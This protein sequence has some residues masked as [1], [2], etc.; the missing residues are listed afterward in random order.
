MDGCNLWLKKRDRRLAGEIERS[1]LVAGLA[2][3]R[4]ECRRG[5]SA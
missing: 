3:K 5:F 2:A 4:K 1:L